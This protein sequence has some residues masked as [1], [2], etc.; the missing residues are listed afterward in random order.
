[1]ISLV[2]DLLSLTKSVVKSNKISC[3][4]IFAVKIVRNFCTV[5]HIFSVKSGSIFAYNMFEIL[6]WR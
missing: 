4:Y 2:E 3:G 1:M 5:P 6:T